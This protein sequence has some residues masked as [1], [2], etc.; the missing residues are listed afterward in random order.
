MGIHLGIMEIHLEFTWE[1]LNSMWK[2]GNSPRNLG[3]HLVFL[4]SLGIIEIYVG[5]HSFYLQI[6]GIHWAILGFHVYLNNCM[7]RIMCEK[8]N[9]QLIEPVGSIGHSWF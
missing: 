8:L 9:I 1:F 6:M 2:L 5:I 3:I 4:T 7:C